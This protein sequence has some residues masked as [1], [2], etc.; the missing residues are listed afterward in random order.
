MASPSL[1]LL[2][3]VDS[4]RSQTCQACQLDE[5]A[6]GGLSKA[7]SAMHHCVR[8]M[9]SYHQGCMR[10]QKWNSKKGEWI[11]N[12]CIDHELGYYTCWIPLGDISF[13]HG[14]LALVPGSHNLT[15][16]NAPYPGRE[17][18]PSSPLLLRLLLV[19]S[20]FVLRLSVVRA[21]RSCPGSTRRPSA[22]A[23]GS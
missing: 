21:A 3:A 2:S 4:W 14:T 10:G 11:C 5:P 20:S 1:S 22:T 6:N 23:G 13:E 9:D 12:G 8:C 15:G 19:P 7:K 16:Y 17:V 18:R